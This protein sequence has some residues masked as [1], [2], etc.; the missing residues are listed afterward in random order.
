M[1]SNPIISTY[2]AGFQLCFCLVTWNREVLPHVTCREITCTSTGSHQSRIRRVVFLINFGLDV[3]V[4]F[5]SIAITTK[6]K[7]SE[8]FPVVD[9]SFLNL[10]IRILSR[11]P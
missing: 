4:L 7:C 3:H 2:F 8:M 10:G 6:H 5:S 1:G 11:H 9:G